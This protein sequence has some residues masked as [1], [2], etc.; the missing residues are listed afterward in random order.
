MA[1]RK[2]PIETMVDNVVKPI[3]NIQPPTD[4][5]P[6]ATHEGVLEIE[7]KTL[8]CYILN[9]GQRIFNMQ[10]VDDFFNSKV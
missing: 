9:T 8:K 4:G 2:L 6:Y 5:T 7:G 10:D 3:V 1:D